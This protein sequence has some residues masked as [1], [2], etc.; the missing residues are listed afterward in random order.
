VETYKAERSVH[1]RE[2]LCQNFNDKNGKDWTSD[3]FIKDSVDTYP[4]AVTGHVF[5][6]AGD[7]ARGNH[8][9]SYIV[10]MFKDTAM[11]SHLN[12]EEAGWGLMHLTTI[13]KK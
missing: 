12:I 5:A 4:F 13:F 8:Q 2:V 10:Q 11:N 1:Q 9:I 7:T 3:Q 6:M